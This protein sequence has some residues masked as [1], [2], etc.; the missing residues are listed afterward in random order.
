VS[1]KARRREV[2]HQNK[3]I[4]T[5]KFVERLALLGG[6]LSRLEEKVF[7]YLWM[8]RAPSKVVADMMYGDGIE[9]SR[10]LFMHYEVVSKIWLD[11][12]QTPNLFIHLDSRGF[13]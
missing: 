7:G 11:V 3:K 12:M 6:E 4:H 13:E 10:H 5:T 2:N 8:S 1:N 9:T